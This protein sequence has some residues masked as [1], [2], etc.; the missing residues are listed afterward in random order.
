MA[1]RVT[2]SFSVSQFLTRLTQQ[3]SRIADLNEQVT[4]GLRINRPSD[5]PAGVRSLLRTEEAI[6][7]LD[8]RVETISAAR[9]RLEQASI[10][11]RDAQTLFVRAEVTASQAVQA[12]EPSE[13]EVL[14]DEIDGLLRQLDGLANVEISGEFLFA[15]AATKSL[16]FA[17]AALSSVT[18]YSGSEIPR[19]LQLHTGP[20]TTIISSG[21]E[22]FQ[23][24]AREQTLFIG[25]T[26]AAAGVGTDSAVGQGTLE[27]AHAATT[28]AAGSGVAA[29][30]DSATAD[31]IIGPAGAYQLNIV[32][33]SGTGAF[34]TVSLNGGPPVAFTNGDTN[35]QVSGPFDETVFIDTTSITAGFSGNVDVTATGTLSTDGGASTVA[36]DFST[37]QAVTDSVTG[38]ITNVDSTAIRF[39]G[40]EQLEYAGTADAF[41]VLRELRDDI[42]NTRGFSPGVQKEAIARRLGDVQRLQDHFLNVTGEQSVTLAQ[43]NDVQDNA[44]QSQLD[45]QQRLSEIASADISQ[46]AIELQQ[47]RS[48]LQ[49]TLATASRL[50]DI[51]LLEFLR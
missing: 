2:P 51:S 46:V 5:D 27:V 14:A 15:G 17:D 4:S 19:T 33:T 36:I 34:G 35:L 18:T 20:P 29:G 13:L 23:P 44:E 43:L 22:V 3:N 39:A 9:Y 26:G 50:F 10:N 31:T 7:R 25:G 11:V 30:T 38:K 48:Q 49:Y 28:Y 8:T 42:R 37:N 47:S 1:F 21:A 32:D 24:K 6:N 45:F 41:Q 40:T 16:P 12:S